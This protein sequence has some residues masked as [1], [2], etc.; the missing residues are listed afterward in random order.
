[1]LSVDQQD[2]SRAEK[3]PK[4][5]WKAEQNSQVMSKQIKFTEMG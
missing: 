5:M 2:Y 1:M 4:S 3:D